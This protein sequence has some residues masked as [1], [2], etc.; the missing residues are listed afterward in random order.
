MK[1]LTKLLP[2][3]DVELVGQVVTIGEG[4]PLNGKPAMLNYKVKLKSEGNMTVL[5]KVCIL[6]S[7]VK[8]KIKTGDF[9]K[10]TGQLRSTRRTVPSYKRATRQRYVLAITIEQ[11]Y[12]LLLEDTYSKV[13]VGGFTSI[14]P[15]NMR[16]PVHGKSKYI[17]INTLDTANRCWDIGLLCS[18]PLRKENYDHDY[19]EAVGSLTLSK[20]EIVVFVDTLIRLNNS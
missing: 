16:H 14:S 11:Q 17:T 10:V 3:N 18:G 7:S 1:N 12:N 13:T 2:H 5:I 6:K 8:S 15:I 19:Y 9:V 20:K 4:L